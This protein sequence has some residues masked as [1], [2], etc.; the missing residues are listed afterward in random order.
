VEVLQREG[1]EYAVVGGNAVRIWVAQVDRTAVRATND[2]DI[3]IRPADME[4]LKKA[5]HEAGFYYR[6]TAGVE[7]FVEQEL[8]SARG[9]VHVVLAGQVVRPNDFEPNP[10]VEPNEVGDNFRT[11]PLETLVRMKLNSYRLKDKVHLLD[12]IGVGLIDASWCQRYPTVLGE[13]LRELIENP[14]Q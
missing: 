13:R 12:M 7:M 6:Q 2:V 3:L 5:M 10:D 8:E 14:N 11:V 1:I 9:V 4:R